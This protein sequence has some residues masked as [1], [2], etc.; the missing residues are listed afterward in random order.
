VQLGSERTTPTTEQNDIRCALKHPKHET[1]I[2]E[3]SQPARENV[4]L[5]DA[6]L[7]IE[8]RTGFSFLGNRDLAVAAIEPAEYL[9]HCSNLLANVSYLR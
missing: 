1:D 7:Y 8:T 2:I 4:T 5:L 6:L 3:A 9:H